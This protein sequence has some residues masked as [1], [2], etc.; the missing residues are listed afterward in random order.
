LKTIREVFK[1]N[2]KR[3]RGRRTKEQLAELAGVAFPT[4]R[5]AERGRIPHSGTLKAIARAF[6]VTEPALFLDP[7][8]APKTPSAEEAIKLLEIIGE[9]SK[10]IFPQISEEEA[11]KDAK[12][13]LKSLKGKP[14]PTKLS[15]GGLTALNDTEL[16]IVARLRTDNFFREMVIEALEGRREG[17]NLVAQGRGRQILDTGTEPEE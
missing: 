7:D 6:G 5:N 9:I 10:V 15:G 17:D 3:L 8:L 13:L 11:K 2:L 1:S 14:F 4:Y 12:A 16:S